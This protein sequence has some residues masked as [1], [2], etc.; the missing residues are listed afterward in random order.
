M[1]F[2]ALLNEDS[3]RIPVVGRDPFSDE[4]SSWP[5]PQYVKDAISGAY[6]L[7]HK[8]AMRPSTAAECAHLE[9]VA[10]WRLTQIVSRIV[11]LS[12]S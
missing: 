6:S 3:R 8:G 1:F 7:Y 10:A 12:A 2:A 5:P 9:P 11:R 4:E